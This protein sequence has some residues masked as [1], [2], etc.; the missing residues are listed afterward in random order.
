[1]SA[2]YIIIGDSSSL[3]REEWLALRRT[4]IGG[5]DAGAVVGASPWGSPLSV[6]ADKR[7]ILPEKDQ[8][9]AMAYGKHAEPMLRE[10]F[11]E[12]FSVHGAADVQAFPQV[13]RSTLY[14][15]ALANLDGAVTVEG[16]LCGLEL[17]TADRSQARHWKEGELPDGYFWQVQHYMAVTGW[18]RFYVFALLG[19]RPLIRVVERNDAMIAE[20]MEAEQHLWAMVEANE[21]PAPSGLDCETDLLSALYQGGGEERVSL[22]PEMDEAMEA[23]RSL[24]ASIKREEREREELAQ[25]IKLAMGNAK[26]GAGATHKATWSRFEV[27]RLDATALKK[28]LPEVAVRF[29]KVSKG[30]RFIVSPNNQKEGKKD[31]D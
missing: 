22:P 27:N 29:T 24:G 20:L 7:G 30:E 12:E 14:P 8:T 18:P 17:K 3:S 28:E 10:W 25:R 1:V 26:V 31:E 9:D 2:P 11:G 4:G 16:V 21:M 19:K 15:W 23:H 6:W 5:S 13:L